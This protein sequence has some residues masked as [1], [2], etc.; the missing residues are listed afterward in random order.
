MV[1]GGGSSELRAAST[2]A[3]FNSGF[4][5]LNRGGGGAQTSSEGNAADAAGHQQKHSAVAGDLPD[6]GNMSPPAKRSK[7]D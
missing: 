6:T 2:S 7:A 3:M 5:Q 1:A 4:L